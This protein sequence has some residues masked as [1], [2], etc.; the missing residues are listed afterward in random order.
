MRTP[1]ITAV[2]VTA[3]LVL[4]P[5][6]AAWATYGSYEPDSTY[7]TSQWMWQEPGPAAGNRVYFNGWS[8]TQALVTPNLGAL[9]SSHEAP[10]MER[11][12]A[13]LGVWVD[14]N[15][16]GFV[17]Q[18]EGALYE[19]SAA[20]LFDTTIC[21]PVT[22]DK[23]VWVEGAHNYNGW[24]TELVPIGLPSTDEGI[25]SDTR[26]YVDPDAKIWA[27]RDRPEDFPRGTCALNP[28][29][30]GTMQS[31]GGL[32]NYLDCRYEVIDLMNAVILATGDPLDLRFP[33]PENAQGAPLDV[34]TFGTE[35]TD[36]APVSIVDCSA[37]PMLDTG[38]EV[39]ETG[40]Q[41]PLQTALDTASD[42]SGED[43]GE[44]WEYYKVTVATIDPRLMNT[45]DPTVPAQVNQSS[46]EI[47]GDCDTS[48]DA[49]H[50]FYGRLN[51][52][53]WTGSGGDMGKTKAT[54]TFGYFEGFRGDMGDFV[55]GEDA[56][57]GEGH[58][59]VP[60]GTQGLAALQPLYGT[61]WFGQGNL[62]K[63]G[64]ASVEVRQ[65]PNNPG[66]EIAG[67]YYVTF[68]A[69]VG[70][71]S[72]GRFLTPGGTGFYGAEACG[73]S[74]EG[75]HGGWDCDAAKWNLNADGTPLPGRER[76]PVVHEFYNLRDVDCYDGN[77]GSLGVGAS[78][79]WFGERP[80][81]RP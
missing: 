59:T 66:V 60:S 25:P 37:P 68:Y 7:D 40:V 44:G 31:T 79:A 22:G 24:V 10:T 39:N 15:G 28:F 41:G 13:I 64:P 8:T 72:T 1:S 57:T 74:D 30:R 11:H 73:E 45:Q 61:G 58:A 63:N 80:C 38:N 51:E 20:L 16:D 6:A 46:E 35:D 18:A 54:W 32:F 3:A 65:D 70:P 81:L 23:D 52:G 33:D 42:A 49:G 17:G 27:D 53:D 77:M 19:Y 43:L 76:F 50:D 26:V 14:C 4:S 75:I 5:L 55:I 9:Q 71:A 29:P 56:G 67:G 12:Q 2:A 78:P 21:P 48:N 47:T 36:H 34:D 69:T 62:V